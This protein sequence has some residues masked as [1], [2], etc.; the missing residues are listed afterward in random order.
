M[1]LEC[2]LTTYV[3]LCNFSIS[4]T[5]SLFV[6]SFQEVK[7]SKCW[8]MKK[9]VLKVH[10]QN[11]RETQRN[12]YLLLTSQLKFETISVMTYS[13]SVFHYFATLEPSSKQQ[14]NMQKPERFNQLSNHRMVMLK[15]SYIFKKVQ[16]KE[17]FFENKDSYIVFQKTQLFFSLRRRKLFRSKSERLLFY[18]EIFLFLSKKISV[19]HD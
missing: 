16:N 4:I 8:Q 17:L 19:T 5:A 10:M 11:A 3:Q 7:E 15:R 6:P 12:E 18:F 14:Q 2:T 1:S 9:K 13:G